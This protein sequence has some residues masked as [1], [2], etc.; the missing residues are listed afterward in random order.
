MMLQDDQPSFY[1]ASIAG[2][3]IPTFAL[4]LRGYSRSL[5]KTPLWWDDW[6]ALVTLVR[7]YD[8]YWRC[9]SSF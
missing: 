9:P 1:A 6:M 7:D 8:P 4:G 3:I 5:S 2:I